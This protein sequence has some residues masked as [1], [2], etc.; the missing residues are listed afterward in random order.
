METVTGMVEGFVYA[1]EENGY[2]VVELSQGD[3]F[4]TAVGTLA[5]LH[6]GETVELSGNWITHPTYGEQFKAEICRALEPDSTEGLERYLAS[7]AIKG[8]G[9]K[10]AARI[11][12]ELGMAALDIIATDPERL[13]KIEGIGRKRALAISEAVLEKRHVQDTMVFLQ[14][15]RLGQ[16]I[17]AKIMKRYE[18]RTVEIIRQNPY[19]LVRDIRGVGFRTADQ[20]AQSLGIAHD[21]PRRIENGMIYVLQDVAQQDGH[22]CLPREELIS[23][24]ARLL[25]ISREKVEETYTRLSVSRDL[26]TR[27]LD[28][29]EF[30]YT[31]QMYSAELEVAERLLLLVHTPVRQ[32]A[33]D[34]EGLV[35]MVADMRTVTLSQEQRNCVL[36]SLRSGVT[37]IT[38]GPGTGKTTTIACLIHVLEQ[39]GETVEL[40]APTGRAAKR[41]QES[42]EHEARTIHRLLEYGYG[43]EDGED[44][45]PAF[46][47]NDEN[48]LECQ[49]VVLDEMSMVDLLLMRSFLRSVR[50]GT[51]LILVGDA[52]QLPSVGPGNVLRNILDSGVI[53]VGRLT[54]I[55]RQA[56]E[57]R[58][59][60]NAHRI[61]HGEMP[62][63]RGG[64]DFFFSSQSTAE[65]VFTTVRDMVGY[66]IPGYLG[67]DPLQDIQVMAPMKKGE[68]GVHRF[69]QRL[70]ETF[71]PP[72]A[73]KGEFQYG[74]MVFREGD[75]VMQIRN[76]YQLE[77]KRV[78]D[79]G[80]EVEGKGVFNGDGG[81]ILQIAPSVREMTILFDDGRRASYPF[82][83]AE[84]LTLAYAIS[85]HKS[86]GSEF[87]VVILPLLSGSGRL[88]TR[89]LLYTAV[90]RAKKMVV[91]V[92]Q[93]KTIAAMVAN[94]TVVRRYSG[95]GQALRTLNGLEE[96]S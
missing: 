29:Q 82:S 65:T 53:P 18:N 67:C 45:E 63:L 51:R 19:R 28:G 74:E 84:D 71:N 47:R 52:D 27:H 36:T 59:V 87:P 15:L 76:N 23:Q 66:R 80:A 5:F 44:D 94:N 30:C 8:V 57:S 10:T 73:S 26:V 77:W 61:N 17:I 22:V 38:G 92:G 69:N 34:L 78:M 31:S 64:K 6:E 12:E 40:A 3:A 83:M 68:V 33:E 90:T 86:Q 2:A 21:D 39:T 13:A 56:Q 41:M 58:I 49:C 11:V 42:T 54:E 75:K 72:D 89:N 79:N 96:E 7:G 60:V 25:G 20:I 16:G 43:A 88:L 70:Q 55:F 91:I 35:D 37:V 32:P 9:E 81:I 1:N 14:S 93:E 4:F 50:P 62:L 46:Q 48:P 95:L 24:S 85:I